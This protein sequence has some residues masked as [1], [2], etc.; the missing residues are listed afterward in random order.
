MRSIVSVLVALGSLVLASL[1][2][3]ADSSGASAA[4]VGRVEKIAFAQGWVSFR[5]DTFF[6]IWTINPDGTKKRRLTRHGGEDPAWSPDGR[7]IA[8]VRVADAAIYVLNV[9]GSGQHRLVSASSSP[10]WSPDGR[11]IAFVRPRG[12]FKYSEIWVVNADG[13]QRRRLT[14]NT[15]DFAPDWSPDGRR[16]V[17]ERGGVGKLAIWVMNADG[18]GQ[19]RLTRNAQND[20]APDWSPDGRRI[21]FGRPSLF[22]SNIWV[23]DADGSGQRKIGRGV[24][25]DPTWSPDGRRIVFVRSPDLYVMNADGTGELRLTRHKVFL[26][27]GNETHDPEWSPRG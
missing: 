23:M 20:Q 3:D 14:R 24:G 6:E 16:I 18:T 21:V 27:G 10:A 17:F 13:T 1:V 11:R 5:G 8:F 4:R 19:R 7:R 26:D 9:D 12:N 2:L 22:W 25:E 15:E